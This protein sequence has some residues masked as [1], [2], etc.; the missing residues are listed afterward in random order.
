MLDLSQFLVRVNGFRDETSGVSFNQHEF[1][2]VDLLVGH[3]GLIK[4]LQVFRHVLHDVLHRDVHCVFYDALVLRADD[5][6]NQLELFEKF[7][8]VV[9]HLVRKYVLLTVDPEVREAFLCG[10]EDFC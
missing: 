7:A 8:T 3:P 1:E 4:L 5:V 6:L 10:V 9:K 2:H